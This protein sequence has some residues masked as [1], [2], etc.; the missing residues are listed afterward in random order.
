M[1]T[2]ALNVLSENR[3]GF[4]LFLAEESVDEFAPT[5]NAHGQGSQDTRPDSAV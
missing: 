2:T 5:N 4:F 1:A 3:D